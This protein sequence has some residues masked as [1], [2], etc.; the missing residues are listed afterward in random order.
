MQS[1]VSGR[2][3]QLQIRGQS[4]EFRLIVSVEGSNCVKSG[5]K[6][7]LLL[8]FSNGSWPSSS[9]LRG[10]RRTYITILKRAWPANFKMV[11]YVLL[12]P[13]RPELDG[14]DPFQIIIAYF[15]RY[16]AYF[17]TSDWSYICRDCDYFCRDWAYFCLDWAY[18]CINWAYFW[19][20]WACFC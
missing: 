17:D 13:L 15:S 9:G 14:Q 8:T 19:R 18:F 2:H 11:W 16:R 7:I 20:D 3:T 12:R 4:G 5:K 1:S 10:H 6:K